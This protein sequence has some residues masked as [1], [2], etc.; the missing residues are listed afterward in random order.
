M[1]INEIKRGMSNVSVEGRVINIEEEREVMTKFGR[2]RVANASIEDE[3]GEITLSLWQEQI[4]RIKEG[5]NVSISGAFVT[6]FRGKLQL[7]IPRS[8]KIEILK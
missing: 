3:T 1:K 2:R 8:G 5:D 6:E 4:D 7:N